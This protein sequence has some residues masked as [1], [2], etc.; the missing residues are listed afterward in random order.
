MN[1]TVAT[2]ENQP[3]EAPLERALDLLAAAYALVQGEV[4]QAE[5]A[6]HDDRDLATEYERTAALYRRRAARRPE[7]AE[8]LTK[9][10]EWFERRAQVKRTG[11]PMPRELRTPA[12]TLAR[13]DEFRQALAATLAMA[14]DFEAN[15]VRCFVRCLA[16][17]APRALGEV[18]LHAFLDLATRLLSYLGGLRG[19]DGDFE[20]RSYQVPL[21]EDGVL[22]RDAQR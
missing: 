1:R 21:V 22:P 10:A 14:S 17:R 2:S 11:G 20:L 8:R 9:R 4:Q 12:E 3:P 6:T 15:D 13:V 18:D 7:E 16:D 19:P 5:R